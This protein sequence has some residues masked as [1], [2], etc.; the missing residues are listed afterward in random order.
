MFARVG[1]PT[2]GQRVQGSGEEGAIWLE[3]AAITRAM[4]GLVLALEVELRNKPVVRSPQL[5][6]EANGCYC[7]KC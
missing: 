1:N 5:T 6:G 4:A 3:L 2:Q 7:T